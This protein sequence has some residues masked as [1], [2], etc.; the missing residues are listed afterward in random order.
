MNSKEKIIGSIVIVVFCCVF[1]F[2]G[3]VSSK[4]AVL[5]NA[6]FINDE[7]SI[8]IDKDGLNKDV[9]KKNISSVS[10]TSNRIDNKSL[11]ITN[12]NSDN[13]NKIFVDIDGAVNNPGVYEI[14]EGSRLVNLIELA[15][16]LTNEARTLGLNKAEELKDGNYY[17]IPKIGEEDD[18][19]FKAVMNLEKK[20]SLININIA[21]LEELMRLPGIGESKGNAIIEYRESVGRF[22]SIDDLANVSGIGGKTVEKLREF[23]DID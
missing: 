18:E 17:Y 3:G 4:N 8:D 1:Y 2:I 12:E 19:D 13:V 21:T 20:S 5:S 11:G 10:E 9:E 15:G 7:Y 23:V 14:D 16:G 22:D 6:D